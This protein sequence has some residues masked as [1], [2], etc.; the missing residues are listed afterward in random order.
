MLHA[1]KL[2]EAFLLQKQALLLQSENLKIG[3]LDM[4]PST[5]LGCIPPDLVCHHL[6]TRFAQHR[7]FLMVDQK[8]SAALQ[9][10]YEMKQQALGRG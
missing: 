10:R 7:K 8:L 9:Q 2:W 4:R 5:R 6:N 3:F 1:H